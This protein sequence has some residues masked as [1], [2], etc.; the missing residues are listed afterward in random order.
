MIVILWFRCENSRDDGMYVV[1]TDKLEPQFQRPVAAKPE[2]ILQGPD[3]AWDLRDAAHNAQAALPA[4][5]E[6]VIN[7]WDSL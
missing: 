6:A 4:K 7:V 1:E 5:V 2:D 3:F